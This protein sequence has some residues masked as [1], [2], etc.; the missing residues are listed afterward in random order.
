MY[1]D[2]LDF[3][4]PQLSENR[5]WHVAINTAMAHPETYYPHN[6]EPVLNDQHS[7]IVGARSVVV[8][9]GK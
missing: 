2:A 6:E 1:W 5:K 9:V 8:L 4:L 7:F 3:D